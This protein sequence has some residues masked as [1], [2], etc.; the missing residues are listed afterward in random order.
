MN[1]KE[2]EYDDNNICVSS[3]KRCFGSHEEEHDMSGGRGG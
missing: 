1:I 2:N 3:Y